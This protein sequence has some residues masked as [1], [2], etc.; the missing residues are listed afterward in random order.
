MPYSGVK[1][2]SE[3]EAKIERCVEKVM[4][5][6]GKSKSAAIAI[7]R[8]SIEK[9][10]AE[11]SDEFEVVDE[12]LPEAEPDFDFDATLAELEAVEAED[13]APDDEEDTVEIEV[14]PNVE[15]EAEEKP[16]KSVSRLKAVIDEAETIL[17][18][19][20][21]EEKAEELPVM[22]DVEDFDFELAQLEVD[23]RRVSED[24]GFFDRIKAVLSSQARK[25]LSDGDFALV[26]NRDGKKV[27]KYPIYDKAHVRNALARAAQQIKAGGQGAAD[28]RAAL[29]KIRAAAKKMGIGQTK[30]N[31]IVV[32][33]NSGENQVE[34]PYRW[35]GIYSNNFQDRE[36]EIITKEA[37]EQFV[38]WLNDEVF[39]TEKANLAPEFRIWHVKGTARKALV[40]AAEIMNDFVVVSGPLTEKEA[41]GLMRVAAK[42]EVGMSHGF[43][44]LK[45][46][47]NNKN[48]ITK[49]RSH[50]V[51][52][53]PVSR[54]AN[55]WT[56]LFSFSLKEA[57][58]NQ[59]LDYLKDQLGEERY[60]ALMADTENQKAILEA[61]DVPSKELETEETPAEDVETKDEPEADAEVSVEEKYQLDK[62]EPY[63]EKLETA[64]KALSA[65]VE[66]QEAKIK[67]LQADEEDHVA[68][69]IASPRHKDQ[70]ILWA[71]DKQR[72][73]V[74]E[75][76]D[77]ELLDAVPGLKEEDWLSKDTGTTPI[78][79]PETEGDAL[80]SVAL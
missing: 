27:R 34:Y 19:L 9:K 45:R 76:A 2:G 42:E 56:N 54:A 18:E 1:P 72:E 6:Q 47:P 23:F 37:H 16:Q 58:M 51:S 52:D 39:G 41:Q 10:E 4:K 57:G 7:C 21:P 80:D 32:V 13:Y 5:E 65:V 8:A 66:Q 44:A 3:T 20:V 77:K 48:I 31:S 22:D 63:L 79:F 59:K 68:D 55:I 43:V 15:P 64:V 35:V 26:V 38:G 75:E 74:D 25:K 29:P 49:Y 46:D 67:A 73:E 70:T 69:L 33:K 62:L 50:E 53:L 60:T 78:P 40:D 14:E 61:L 11:M 28:A 71:R 12:E 30:A 24:V 17:A 36:G